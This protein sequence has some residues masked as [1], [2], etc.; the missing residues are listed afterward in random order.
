MQSIRTRPI[1]WLKFTV[2][3]PEVCRVHHHS[4]GA[5]NHYRCYQSVKQQKITSFVIDNNIVILQLI[6]FTWLDLLFVF[7]WK[8]NDLMGHREWFYGVDC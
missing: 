4:Y 7:K 5:F 3:T 6:L 1:Y 2:E 8:K